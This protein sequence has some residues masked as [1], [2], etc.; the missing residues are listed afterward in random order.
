MVP[1]S[2]SKIQPREAARAA[3]ARLTGVELVAVNGIAASIAQTS[4]AAVGTDRDQ[5]PT[6]TP[7]CTWLGLAPHHD[8][9]GGRVWRWRTPN[10]VRRA[11]QALRQAAPSV[12]RSASAVGAYG[13]ALRARLGPPQATVAT[14]PTIA[15]VVYHLLKD[16]QPF[17]AASAATDHRTRRERDLQH[18]RR[19][20]QKLGSTFTPVAYPCSIRRF[21]SR[22]WLDR[23]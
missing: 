12:A 14:A 13:R 16:R 8:S 6:L 10:V 22:P 23:H 9:S 11:T 7:C 3:L 20:A 21:L 5:F 15:R 18:R 1:G 17:T 19:R 4:I 2:T